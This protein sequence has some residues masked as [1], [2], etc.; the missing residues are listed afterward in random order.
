MACTT[1]IYGDIQEDRASGG[2]LYKRLRHRT[3]F[4]KCTGSPDAR[5][6]ILERISIDEMPVI[7]EGKVRL[8]DWEADTVIGKGHKGALVRLAERVFKR[9][10]IAMC[11]PSMHRS[12][13]TLSLSR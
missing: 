4:K 12:L 5:G 2:D 1:T 11:Y 10:L 3:P 7:I 8:G 13:K 9:T 6:Q